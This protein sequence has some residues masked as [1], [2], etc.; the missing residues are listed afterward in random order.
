MLGGSRG[1][2]SGL[3]RLRPYIKFELTCQGHSLNWATESMLVGMEG[4]PQV[5]TCNWG[6]FRSTP[7]RSVVV[8]A[9]VGTSVSPT[10]IFVTLDTP[11]WEFRMTMV[12]LKDSALQKSPNVSSSVTVSAATE[13]RQG[14]SF[15]PI[16]WEVGNS[17]RIPWTPLVNSRGIQQLQNL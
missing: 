16:T 15:D 4:D 10:V 5:G 14:V 2:D 17:A 1:P 9:V 6:N 3:L 7:R 11:P 8:A 13:R 12:R